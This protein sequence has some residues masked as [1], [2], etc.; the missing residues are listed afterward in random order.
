MLRAAIERGKALR[1]KN[2]L[3][4]RSATEREKSHLKNMPSDRPQGPENLAISA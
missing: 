4:P 1:H 3:P 2:I